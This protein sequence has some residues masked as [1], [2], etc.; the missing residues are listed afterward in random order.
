MM[1]GRTQ[2]GARPMGKKIA[3]LV[4]TLAFLAATYSATA[5]QPGKIYRIGVLGTSSERVQGVFVEFL[6]S[7]LRDAG[8]VDGRNIVLDVRFGNSNRRRIAEQAAELVRRKVDVIVVFGLGAA[9]AVAKKSKTIPIVI[10]IAP[11]LLSSGLVAS[12]AK[13]GGNVTG[14]T[15]RSLDLLTKWLQLTKEILPDASR[16][17]VLFNPIQRTSPSSIKYLKSAAASIGV[18]IHEAPVRAPGDFEEA[19]AAMARARAD[20]LI[21]F[22]GRVTGGNRRELIA[23]AGRWKIPAICWRPALVRLGCLMSY[24]A[25]RAHVVRRSASYV[26]RILRG[27]KAADLPIEQ[28]TKFQFVLNLKAAKA[29]G[30]TFPPAILLRATEVIE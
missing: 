15:S 24:G 18:T 9:Y 8:Y 3:I 6:R 7:G 17:A 28:P 27:A 13:P 22:P 10:G 1:G 2:N 25:N 29:L 26:T 21:M 12:L 23:L 11:D 19:F 4:A 30:I 20:A 14:M 5:Q 16:V